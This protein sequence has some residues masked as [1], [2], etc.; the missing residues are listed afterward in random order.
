M[1]PTC[2]D[3]VRHTTRFIILNTKMTVLCK[4][5]NI[6]HHFDTQIIMV[7]VFLYFLIVFVVLFVVFL[8]KVL[9]STFVFFYFSFVFF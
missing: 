7:F 2:K 3:H 9:F 1:N 4:L 5:P 6:F 8:I